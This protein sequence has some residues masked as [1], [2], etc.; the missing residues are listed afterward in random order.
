MK[1]GLGVV[2][3]SGQK[4]TFASAVDWPGWSR[5]GRNADEALA[6]LVAYGPRYVRVLRD[7]PGFQPPHD[8]D[9]LE[10]I[11][12]LAGGSGTDF[13]V[14]SSAATADDRPID[15][16]EL[17]RQVDIL[18]ACWSYLDRAADRARGKTLTTGPRGGGRPLAKIVG[19]VEE[20]QAAYLHQLGSRP[21]R[22]A[23]SET[24][25]RLSIESLRARVAGDALPNANQVKR[26]WSPR[27][28]L[29]RAAWHVLDHAWEIE[30]RSGTAP[31]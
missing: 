27:Y 25:R 18:E 6:A 24:I 30:D 10:I 14:P 5:A 11:Q 8:V 7:A 26:P 28:F 17:H 21:P 12:R 16:D 3:E 1:A 22:G 23:D 19:H 2:V 4:R 29:R 9:D 31:A 15:T 20:A 13:G